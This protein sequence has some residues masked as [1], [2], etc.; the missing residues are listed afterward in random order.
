MS[1]L[2]KKVPGRELMVIDDVVATIHHLP[3]S[4]HH[5]GNRQKAARD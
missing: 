3:R 1:F 2:A 5:G 4:S